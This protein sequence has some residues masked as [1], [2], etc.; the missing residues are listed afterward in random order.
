M[1][2]DYSRLK[3][4]PLFASLKEEDLAYISSILKLV[5]YPAGQKIVWQG[6][7]GETFYIVDTGQVRVIRKDESGAEAVVRFLGPGQFFGE[8][9]LLY[10]ELR[11]ATVE[12]VVNTTL[13]YIEKDDFAAMVARLP[14]VRKQLEATA[15]G[16]RSKE[17]GLGRFDWQLS[18]EVVVWMAHRN[19]IPL[20][21]ESLGGLI[22]G[23]GIAAALAVLALLRIPS[24]DLPPAG[25]LL[26]GLGAAVMF[27][28]TLV[29]YIYDW[30]NDYLVLTNRRIL[31]LKRYGFLREVRNEVPIQAVQNVVTSHKGFLDAILGLS[32]ITIETFGGKFKFTHVP[33]AEHL[34]ER[35]LDQLVQAED[36]D[37]SRY[38]KVYNTL[39]SYS[40]AVETSHLFETL[41]TLLSYNSLSDLTGAV[42]AVSGLTQRDPRIEPH[43]VVTLA[44]LGN[45]GAEIATCQVATSHANRFASLARAAS[46]LD[47]LDRYVRDEVMPP[48]Q[49]IVQRISRQWWRIISEAST[50]MGF[51]K[52]SGPVANP[53][54]VGNPVIGNTFVGREDVLRRLEELWAKEGQSPSVVLYGHRR[55][56]K[57]SILHNLGARFGASTVIVDFNLQRTGLVA[58]TGEL[59]HNLALALYDSLPQASERGLAELDESQFT[60]HNPYTAF[61]RFL[62]Q[63]DRVRARRRF[64]V[65]VDEFELIEAKIAEGQL[66]PHLLDFWRGVIQTYP[67]L[68]MAF[69]GLH[70]LQEMTRDY[71]HPLYGSVTAIPVSFLGPE[72]ARR[73]I[74]QPS[75]DFPLDYDADA[76]E[77]IIALTHGQ[78]YLV[79]LA[80][81]A[82]VTRFNRQ[83]FEDTSLAFPA[84]FPVEF[85]RERR[86]TLADVEAVIAAQEFFRDGDAYFTGVWVQAERSEPPGQTAVLRAL[87]QLVTNDDGRRTNVEEIARVAGCA[88]EVVQRALETLARHDVVTQENGRWRFTVELMRRWVAQKAET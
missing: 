52:E 26:L 16:R 14:S 72:A 10:D 32:D 35:I 6:D 23:F 38:R 1:T 24:M 88:P 5:P 46:M 79:Q 59:L 28:L 40:D 76:I 56:G 66:E 22:V 18:D 33:G 55:M 61:D 87:A 15:G 41:S 34:K 45:V 36:F 47:N 71:W 73:L 43:M 50:Q 48:D 49:A 27:S 74:T 25:R 63:L 3:A 44:Q 54:V 7:E 65:A 86:F 80:G 8:T 77:R 17:M 11:N 20:I 39:V 78:P 70:T 58:S 31:H 57:S 21:F 9:A 60:A 2:A 37:L 83:M 30:T 75:P 53:Y 13:W 64:I 69:A 12:T 19:V 81:H 29:W 85:S 82:L 84:S 51:S 42:N 4:I 62:K 67:W 68:I